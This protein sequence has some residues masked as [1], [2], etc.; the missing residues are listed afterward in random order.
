MDLKFV[1]KNKIGIVAAAFLV[2]LLSQSKSLHF[3]L[4]TIL[5]RSIIV[6]LILGISSF[7]LM[8]GIIAVLF[9][10]IMINQNGS[11]YL[12]GL[13]GM[14]SDV[15]INKVIAAVKEAD[16]KKKDSNNVAL[17]SSAST[18]TNNTPVITPATEGFNGL[19]GFDQ[20]GRERNLQLGKKS[21]QM[22]TYNN[23]EQGE[24]VLPSD[25][26]SFIGSYSKV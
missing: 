7:N 15:D 10:I 8:F 16:N 24:N 11:F 3:L 23:R 20:V 18:T 1:S 4:H 6:L 9:V 13:E 2:I 26:Y 12:E 19:E 25:Q 22:P 17:Q 21:N 5:G 14:P